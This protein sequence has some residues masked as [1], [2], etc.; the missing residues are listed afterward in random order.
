MWALQSL[1]FSSPYWKSNPGPIVRGERHDMTIVRSPTT[2]SFHISAKPPTSNIVS[3]EK[4]KQLFESIYPMQVFYPLC[5]SV[6]TLKYCPGY[7][8]SVFCG[9]SV[10]WVHFMS[11]LPWSKNVQ[12]WFLFCYGSTFYK[13][14]KT[15]SGWHIKVIC[16]Y[17]WSEIVFLFSFLESPEF[18]KGDGLNTIFCSEIC[19]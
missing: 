17:F 14:E 1:L 8:Y 19:V 13:L 5:L 15:K 3:I 6:S 2:S 7:P 18:N 16:V 4:G 11:S 9:V 12:I 10:F